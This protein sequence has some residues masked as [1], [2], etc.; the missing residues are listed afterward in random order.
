ME[1]GLNAG[2]TTGR[3]QS[4]SQWSESHRAQSSIDWAI[5]CFRYSL[6]WTMEHSLQPKRNSR[7]PY[8]SYESNKYSLNFLLNGDLVPRQL[9]KLKRLPYFIL[10]SRTIMRSLL[11][12]CGVITNFKEP[13]V[14]FK[15]HKAFYSLGCITISCLVIC[16]EILHHYGT[17]WITVL[18][19]DAI[20]MLRSCVNAVADMHKRL[21]QAALRADCSF[22]LFILLIKPVIIP[23]SNRRAFQP[24]QT[25]EDTHKLV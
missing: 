10:F 16:C 19:K 14:L 1:I 24:Q 5:Q 13:P 22:E 17:E 11:V 21:E 2:M 9:K 15:C 7:L 3:S 6:N 12:Q 8:F 25:Y 20:R 18:F 23:Q 4:P